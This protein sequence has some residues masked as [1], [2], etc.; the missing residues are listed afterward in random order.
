MGG[1][2]G[3]KKRIL[4][5]FLSLTLFS[6]TSSFPLGSAAVE[7]VDV[8]GVGIFDQTPNKG[9][10]T[11][12]N[13]ARLIQVRFSGDFYDPAQLSGGQKLW[14]QN[15]LGDYIKINGKTVSHWNAIEFNSVQIHVKTSVALGGQ[16]LEV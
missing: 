3:M 5:I 16:Y 8:T 2:I 9:I 11:F 10:H 12:E 1:G 7:P 15:E 14:V 13:G 4:A 6:I